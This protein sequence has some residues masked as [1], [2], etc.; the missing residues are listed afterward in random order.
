VKTARI[1]ETDIAGETFLGNG[2]LTGSIE[3]GAAVSQPRKSRSSGE[4]SVSHILWGTAGDQILWGTVVGD[5]IL[6]GTAVGDQILWGTS[7]GD[8][9]LWGTSTTGDQIL[10][11]T[12]TGDQILWGTSAGDQILWGTADGA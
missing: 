7:T 3:S 11:G 12:S 6:W 2:I 9:I 4:I 1:S 8:Q 10:W 5:Q